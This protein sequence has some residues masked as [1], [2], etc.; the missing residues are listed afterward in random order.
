MNRGNTQKTLLVDLF[1][2]VI[3]NLGD[4]GVCWRISRQLKNEYGANVRLIVDDLSPFKTLEPR[5]DLSLATQTIDT[6]A[7]TTWHEFEGSNAPCECDLAIE[8]FA[9]DPPLAYVESMARR[10]TKPVWINLEYLSAEDWV[11]GVHGLPS[12]HPRLLLTKY[13]FVPGFT[14][15]SGGLV[16]ERLLPLQGGGRR[17][18]GFHKTWPPPFPTLSSNLATSLSSLPLRGRES[19]RALAFTYPHAPVR[20]LAEAFARADEPLQISL[21]APL[22]D[23]EPSW[24]QIV[25]VPQTEFDELLSQFDVLLVRGED[26]FLRAQYA[27][28]PMLW[29]IYPTD[30]R[31]HIKKLDAWLDRYCE[32]MEP[33]LAQIYRRAS[34]AFVD[35]DHEA[36]LEDAFAAFAR[37]L[38]RLHAHAERWCD[39][40]FAATDLATRLVA[41]YRSKAA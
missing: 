12:P 17:G 32:K 19:M 41:L 1:C 25:P 39:S 20:A 21:A 4:L 3:D 2:R 26:S 27:A 13:F 16:R 28:K 37:A 33:D 40:L 18:M 8:A 10:A 15:K 11:D 35:P 31:A 7:V 34:Q 38:P 23:A 36:S 9:C 14:E 6:I 5:V 24:P 22:N 30:D 29:H